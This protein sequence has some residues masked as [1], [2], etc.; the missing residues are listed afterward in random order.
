MN[1]IG[2]AYDVAV[3]GAGPAGLAAAS[4]CARFGLSTVLLDED[5]MVVM[6]CDRLFPLESPSGS[7]RW[8]WM[9]L[10]GATIGHDGAHVL[11]AYEAERPVVEVV[12]AKIVD[13]RSVRA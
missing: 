4:V 12:A 9:K 6:P 7:S 11:A 2:P 8:S 5:G 1:T 10:D 3:V 13:H